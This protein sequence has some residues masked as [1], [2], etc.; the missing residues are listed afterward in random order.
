MHNA[1]KQAKRFVVDDELESWVAHLNVSKGIN[2]VPALTLQEARVVKQ[3]IGVEAPRTHRGA[4]QWLQRWRRRR[5]LRLRK[6]P[7]LERLHERDMHGKA[8]SQPDAK[9]RTHA[10][11]KKTRFWFQG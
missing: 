8:G 1:I 7:V 3:R 2:P 5:E 10:F 4:R 11:F 6:F 9:K